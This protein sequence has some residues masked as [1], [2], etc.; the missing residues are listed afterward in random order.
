M[1]NPWNRF[2]YIIINFVC[3]QEIAIEE[4][5][6]FLGKVKERFHDES[7][8]TFFDKLNGTLYDELNGTFY[9]ESDETFYDESDEIYDES[10]ETFYDES[11]SENLTTFGF[12]ISN[13]NE[14][15]AEVSNTFER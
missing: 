2:I 1:K 7:N 13:F 10:D 14:K 9:D 5:E 8:G 3:C 15:H 6:T 4:N 11:I 12:E